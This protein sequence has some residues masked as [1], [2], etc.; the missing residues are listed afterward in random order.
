MPFGCSLPVTRLRSADMHVQTSAP[1]TALR[2]AAQ[3]CPSSLDWLFRLR[4]P[5]GKA[6]Q[7][8]PEM[9]ARDWPADMGTCAPSTSARTGT[10]TQITG[11]RASSRRQAGC[12][13]IPQPNADTGAHTRV[14]PC[15]HT[16]LFSLKPSSSGRGGPR[17]LWQF[18]RIC[19]H[20]RGECTRVGV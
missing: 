12:A 1:A 2:G 10:D 8:P 3:L 19:K 16:G 9:C 18:Q 13:H 6:R 11:P 14:P 7:S 15:V 4:V 5:Q 17:G 20:W